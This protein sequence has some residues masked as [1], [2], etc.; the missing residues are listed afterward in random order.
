VL[1]VAAEFD[2]FHEKRISSRAIC[3]TLVRKMS[4]IGGD[5]FRGGRKLLGDGHDTSGHNSKF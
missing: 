5:K 4:R 1:D 3:R 2:F